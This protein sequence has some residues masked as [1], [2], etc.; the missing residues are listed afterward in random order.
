MGG[1]QALVSPTVGHKPVEAGCPADPTGSRIYCVSLAGSGKAS[2]PLT[3]E[4]VT[5]NG[6]AGAFSYG[7]QRT[8]K[9]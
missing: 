6:G 1:A 5:S 7:H 4:M 2:S 8:D 3:G 9:F